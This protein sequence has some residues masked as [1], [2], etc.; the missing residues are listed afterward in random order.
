MERLLNHGGERND[1]WDNGN[2]AYVVCGFSSVEN[3]ACHSSAPCA[4]TDDLLSIHGFAIYD[5][6]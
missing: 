3:G 6:L 2:E 5:P 1:A 4:V